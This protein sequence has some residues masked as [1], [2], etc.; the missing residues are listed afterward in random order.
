[1]PVLPLV[2]STIVA[3][4]AR[5]PSRS[6]ASTIATAM[7]SLTLPAGLSDSSLPSTV[8]LRGPGSRFSRTSGVLP[9]SSSTEPATHVARTAAPPPAAVPTSLTCTARF[10]RQKPRLSPFVYSLF[11]NTCSLDVIASVGRLP[12]ARREVRQRRAVQNLARG[13]VDLLPH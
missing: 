11:P 10:I 6:A 1:M 12:P 13:V 5:R 7:R 9:T 3:P 2:G 8:A 4:G